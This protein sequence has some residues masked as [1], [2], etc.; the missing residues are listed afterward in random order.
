MPTARQWPV[1]AAMGRVERAAA[2]AFAA[3]TFITLLLQRRLLANYRARLANLAE[4]PDAT[5]KI[6]AGSF[7]RQLR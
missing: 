7:W 6:S 2:V 5:D 3:L 4:D 1:Q